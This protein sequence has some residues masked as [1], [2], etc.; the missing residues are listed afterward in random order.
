MAAGGQPRE[1]D[2]ERPMAG[3]CPLGYKA[4]P[5]QFSEKQQSPHWLYMKE[6]KVR[7]GTRSPYPK[8]RTLFI[9]NVPPYCLEEDLIQLLSCCG[10]VQSLE[11]QEKPDLAESRPEPRSR[12]FQPRPATFHVAYVV[13]RK[14]ASVH[15]AMSLGRKGPLVISSESR[16]VKTGIQKWIADYSAS[17]VDPEALK[18]EVDTFMEKYDNEIAKEDAKAEEE[19]GV[20]DNEGW[21]KVTRKGRRPGIPRTEAASL[22]LL[23]KEK[24]KRTRKELLNFYAWQHRETKREHLAQLRKKFE[25]DKQRIALMRAQRKFRPY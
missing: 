8:S 6:H 4:V 2:V 15:L 20:P 9:L 13:F 23:E 18:V 19:E 21:V 11:L 16:P 1:E 25:E 12:F 24:Q 14:P 10:K 22:R 3:P 7:E 5:I 17:L